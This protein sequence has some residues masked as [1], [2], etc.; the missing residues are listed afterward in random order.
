MKRNRHN[1]QLRCYTVSGCAASH[2]LCTLQHNALK[3]EMEFELFKTYGTVLCIQ[4]LRKFG[5]FGLHS[6][7]LFA[8]W[9][10]RFDRTDHIGYTLTWTM[11]R[12]T[13]LKATSTSHYYS[14]HTYY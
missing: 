6:V 14:G 9:P 8:L 4:C 5:P 10:L 11:T 13:R 3:I 7:R 1:S 12:L 2:T